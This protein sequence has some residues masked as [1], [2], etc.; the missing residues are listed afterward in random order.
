MPI[1]GLKQINKQKNGGTIP[2]KKWKIVIPLKI[3]TYVSKTSKTQKHLV[4][5]GFGYK[6]YQYLSIITIV[7]L[8]STLKEILS[9]DYFLL[10]FF[11]WKNIYQT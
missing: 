8:I 5:F 2:R 9:T 7:N 4:T 11:S 10:T 1:I 6:C 3:Y